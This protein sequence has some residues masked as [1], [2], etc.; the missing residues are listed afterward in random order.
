MLLVAD[1]YNVLHAGKEV[2]DVSDDRLAVHL[3]QRLGHGVASATKA[4]AKSGHWNDDLK[5]ASRLH[6]VEVLDISA[7]DV[8]DDRTTINEILIAEFI[9]TN[10]VRHIA[11]SQRKAHDEPCALEK[12]PQIV[13]VIF[14]AMLRVNETTAGGASMYPRDQAIWR[15]EAERATALQNSKRGA[16]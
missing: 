2:G 12:R 3:N 16:T 6:A 8:V 9:E 1:E 13:G 15:I 11:N 4:L 5:H 7:I 14:D 10:G